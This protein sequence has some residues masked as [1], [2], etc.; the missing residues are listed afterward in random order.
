MEKLRLSDCGPEISGLFL[1]KQTG[2]DI[3]L[4]V[5]ENSVKQSCYRLML[6]VDSDL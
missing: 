6:K 5:T 2:E 4:L 1:A 3:M